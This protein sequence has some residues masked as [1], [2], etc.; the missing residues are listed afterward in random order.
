[1]TCALYCNS[2]SMKTHC[3]IINKENK[4]DH[5]FLSLFSSFGKITDSSSCCTGGADNTMMNWT[6]LGELGLNDILNQFLFEYG[7]LLEDKWK[8]NMS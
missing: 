4:Q 7:K 1:M 5:C 2:S 8:H 3:I 6:Y